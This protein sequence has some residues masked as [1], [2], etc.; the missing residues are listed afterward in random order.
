MSTFQD[1]KRLQ[2]QN[3]LLSVQSGSFSRVLC[4]LKYSLLVFSTELEVLVVIV[5]LVGPD[6]RLGILSFL[7]LSK[8]KTLTWEEFERTSTT[9]FLV[10]EGEP[11][12][13]IFLT[14]FIFVPLLILTDLSLALVS[15]ISQVWK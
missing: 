15:F 11:S 4:S 8:M 14:C 1:L 6:G 2:V 9:R 10:E 5:S 13:E 3:H 7:S 12:L